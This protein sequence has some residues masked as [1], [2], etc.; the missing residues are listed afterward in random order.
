MYLTPAADAYQGIEIYPVVQDVL[1]D[2]PGGSPNAMKVTAPDGSYALHA[3]VNRAGRIVYTS[4]TARSASAS[5]LRWD[6]ARWA[7]S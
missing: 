1:P 2:A 7:S 6:P 3:N 5:S 4:P